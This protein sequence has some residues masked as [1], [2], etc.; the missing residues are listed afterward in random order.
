MTAMTKKQ[1]REVVKAKAAIKNRAGRRAM[2][3]RRAI[4]DRQLQRGIE[5]E[6]AMV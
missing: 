5:K 3:I 2:T 6:E 1:M 4:E